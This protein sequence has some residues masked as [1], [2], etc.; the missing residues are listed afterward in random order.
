[1]RRFTG[2]RS[3][4]EAAF[5]LD[6]VVAAGGSQA[7]RI[8]LANGFGAELTMRISIDGVEQTRSA[9]S[10]SIAVGARR[11]NRVAVAGA[12]FQHIRMAVAEDHRAPGPA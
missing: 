3:G 10:V 6:D 1:M 5:E 8:A 11:T 4:R 2:C 9:I 7:R 12:P